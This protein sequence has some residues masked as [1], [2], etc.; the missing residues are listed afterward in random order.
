MIVSD[1]PA[2]TECVELAWV[3]DVTHFWFEELGEACWFAKNDEIDARIR[4]RF[5][6]LH[7]QLV[8]HDGFGVSAPRSILAAVIVMDQFSRNLFRA[9]ARA[10]SADP[11][12]RRLSRAAI[13]QG[14]ETTLKDRQERYFLYLP[15]EHSEDHRDQVLALT[16]IQQLG[17]DKWTRDAAEHMRI[18]ERF[19][20]FP[21]RNKALKRLSTADELAYLEEPPTGIDPKRF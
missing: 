18:I 3:G 13:A 5:L 16:M 21:R 2:K 15:F 17:N 19:G 20:R 4:D 11:I 14:F 7:E 12:A 6:P 8:E 9:D 1:L 10:F